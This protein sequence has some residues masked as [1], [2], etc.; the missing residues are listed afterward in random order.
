MFVAMNIINLAKDGDP[1]DPEDWS[2]QRTQSIAPLAV[3]R[4]ATQSWSIHAILDG[5]YMVYRVLVPEPNG[6]QSTSQPV[7]SS[8]IHM[9][10]TPLPA[11][12]PRRSATR[13]RNANWL[14]IASVYSTVE[15]KSQHQHRSFTIKCGKSFILK[16]DEQMKYINT[17]ILSID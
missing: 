13:P 5:N 14:D 6:P 2:P 7:V 12:I 3:G 17:V 11:S 8:G 4:S 10:V 9:T 16:G 15:S 1:V